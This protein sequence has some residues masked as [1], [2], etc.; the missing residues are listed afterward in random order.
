M[1]KDLIRAVGRL[2]G[3]LHSLS[4]RMEGAPLNGWRSTL[5]GEMS[6][7]VPS[8]LVSLRI[9]GLR[10][11]GIPTWVER[12]YKLQKITLCNTTLT[13]EKL[14]ALSELPVLVC[15]RLRHKSYNGRELAFRKPGGFPSLKFLRIEDVLVVTELSFQPN[16]MPKL[17]EIV[18]SLADHSSNDALV[19][20]ITV[21][22]AGVENL[23]NLKNVV[24]KGLREHHPSTLTKDIAKHPNRPVFSRHGH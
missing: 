4:V 16:S 12:L 22:V 14:G 5:D 8:N 13:D 15:L 10:S 3:C 20:A 6:S 11:S 17:Q 18:W 9:D 21:S 1:M 23:P 24:L 2:S 7:P 19:A